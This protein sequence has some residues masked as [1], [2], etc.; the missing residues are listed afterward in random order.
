[1]WDMLSDT[2]SCVLSATFVPIYVKMDIV[3]WDLRFIIVCVKIILSV[4]KRH[5]DKLPKE[6]RPKEQ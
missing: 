2:A 3:F 6:E 1:M 4:N 5:L